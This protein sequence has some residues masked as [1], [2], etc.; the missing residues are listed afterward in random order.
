[1]ITAGNTSFKG[2][3]RHEHQEEVNER[4][5]KRRKKGEKEKRKTRERRDGLRCEKKTESD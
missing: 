5:L 4:T 3:W 1:M 2:G